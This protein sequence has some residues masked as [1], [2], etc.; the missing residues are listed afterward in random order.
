M[1]ERRR[2][3]VLLSVL[4]IVVLGLV[5]VD[6]RAGQESPL[7]RFREGANTV[8][9]PLQEGLTAVLSPVTAM[10]GEVSELLDLR[11]E[12]ER[13]RAEL[14]QQRERRRAVDDVMREN[15]S[16]RRL[17]EVREDLTGSGEDFETLTAQV[18]SLAPSNFE[19]TVSLDVGERHGVRRD[20]AVIS[21]DGIV[22]RVVQVGP[23]VSRVLLAVDRS[24]SA[25]VRLDRTGE[26]G[27]V[28]GGGTHPLRLQLLDPEADVRVGDQVVTSSYRNALFPDGLPVGRVDAV[29][30]DDGLLT[31]DV[32]VRPFVDFTQLQYVLVIVRAPP[33]DPLPLPSPGTTERSRPDRQPGDA[34]DAWLRQRDGGTSPTPT[35]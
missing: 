24:F 34:R 21:G 6:A 33:P 14:E 12:N 26:H 9:G 35:P 18:I 28:E 20:M 16:L 1:Y 19:W 13:L 29:G 10:T 11:G 23:R 30:E 25:A 8:F 2:A 3:R 32:Q 4:T 17:L 7:Q 5:T 22:G 27:F 31:R 15:E